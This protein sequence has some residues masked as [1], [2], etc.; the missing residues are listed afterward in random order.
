MNAENEKNEIPVYILKKLN[1]N[2]DYSLTID[3]GFKFIFKRNYLTNT[4]WHV[5]QE[6]LKHNF[7]EI[8]L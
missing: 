5:T 2:S 1:A 8:C 6:Y 3:N 7:W 4:I